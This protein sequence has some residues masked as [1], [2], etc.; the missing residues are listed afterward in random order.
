MSA[1]FGVFQIKGFNIHSIFPGNRDDIERHD[2][3]VQFSKRHQ[4]VYQEITSL[5]LGLVFPDTLPTD[6]ISH[7]SLAESI[8][9]T[10]P[11]RISFGSWDAL[12]QSSQNLLVVGNVK[13]NTSQNKKHL[14]SLW[15]NRR[16]SVIDAEQIQHYVFL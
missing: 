15:T 5:G 1:N 13:P 16:T 4:G 12:P 2:L 7:A 11:L 14:P 9:S 3:Q 10:L 6:S 8:V